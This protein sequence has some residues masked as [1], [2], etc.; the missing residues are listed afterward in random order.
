MAQLVSGHRR[1]KKGNTLSQEQTKQ[2]RR[3]SHNFSTFLSKH[4]FWFTRHRLLKYQQSAVMTFQG[5][6]AQ[7]R[8]MFCTSYD[9]PAP[10][11]QLHR[12]KLK[13]AAGQFWQNLELQYERLSWPP[14]YEF[15][16]YRE[17]QF[18]KLN[19]DLL[20]PICWPNFVNC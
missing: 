17:T 6:S 15:F 9:Q 5:K 12:R 20:C 16:Q 7:V 19:K 18:E 10:P 2:T 14:S 1:S 8:F 11:Q 4:I 13:T 3:N